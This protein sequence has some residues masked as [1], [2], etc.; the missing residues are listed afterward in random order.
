MFPL[1]WAFNIGH[2]ERIG[3]GGWRKI[4]G[5]WPLFSKKIVKGD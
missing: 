4:R 5:F 2:Y 3:G 1:T